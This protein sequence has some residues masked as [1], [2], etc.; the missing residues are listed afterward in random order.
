[1][2]AL[3]SLTCLDTKEYVRTVFLPY[4]PGPDTNFLIR[5]LL[6]LNELRETHPLFGSIPA[7]NDAV[8]AARKRAEDLLATF[9]T[10]ST[11]GE[12]WLT[13]KRILEALWN[14]ADLLARATHSAVVLSES[15]L[16]ATPVTKTWP[17]RA[18]DSPEAVA[19]CAAG[20]DEKDV[21][22]EKVDFA[23]T[24]LT[25]AYTV[26]A[27]NISREPRLVC[28]TSYVPLRYMSSIGAIGFE[29]YVDNGVCGT[30]F[31]TP[32]LSWLIAV[33]RA[34]F[35]P[36][37]SPGWPADLKEALRCSRVGAGNKLADLRLDVSAFFNIY[38]QLY[39]SP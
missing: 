38:L 28:C 20:N 2:R 13:D 34:Y 12:T 37:D 6:V 39:Q 23:R 36:T 4:S 18:I 30:S 7:P 3:E 1:M 33:A 14:F 16:L 19:V 17:L 24:S 32:R 26:A 27:L 35:E 11:V 25:S 29:G 21:V 9:P 31:S 5:E 15:W 22:A 10:A 8:E